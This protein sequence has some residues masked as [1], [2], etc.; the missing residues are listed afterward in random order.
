MKRCGRYGR[1]D[2]KKTRFAYPG[3]LGLFNGSG[4]IFR[5]SA[6]AKLPFTP[7]SAKL[8]PKI[9][10]VDQRYIVKSLGRDPVLKYT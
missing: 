6:K 5:C 9:I 7:Q 3:Q 1:T 8:V 2:V 10:M 4:V